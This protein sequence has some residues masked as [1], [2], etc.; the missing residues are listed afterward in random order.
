MDEINRMKE[1]LANCSAY[2]DKLSD[3]EFNTI[4]LELLDRRLSDKPKA[5]DFI[6]LFREVVSYRALKTSINN[7]TKGDF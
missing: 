7:I 1:A 6:N 4:L 3:V 5:R 2:I